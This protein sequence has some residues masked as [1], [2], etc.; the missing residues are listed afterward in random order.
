MQDQTQ[1]PQRAPADSPADQPNVRWLYVLEDNSLHYLTLGVSTDDL[2]SVEVGSVAQV[3]D[4]MANWSGDADEWSRFKFEFEPASVDPTPL[5]H[6]EEWEKGIRVDTQACR[7]LGM[8]ERFA[9]MLDNG[10]DLLLDSMPHL[11]VTRDNY[12]S[13]LVELDTTTSMIDEQASNGVLEYPSDNVQLVNSLGVVTK[14]LEPGQVG[15]PKLRVVVDAAASGVND[16]IRDT[17]F[18]MP[19]IGNVVKYSRKG[20]SPLVGSEI[21]LKRWVLSY[22]SLVEVHPPIRH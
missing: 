12:S 1:G 10:S 7:K 9:S 11:D 15:K 18:P 19:K 16:C 22:S 6:T 14:K 20:W 3:G 13:A 5:L 2:I 17:P 8:S 21:R 4:S